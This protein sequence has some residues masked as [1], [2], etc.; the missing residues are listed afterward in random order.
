MPSSAGVG[1]TGV[2]DVTQTPETTAGVADGE[3]TGCGGVEM[4]AAD[5]K[6][7]RTVLL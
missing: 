6:P 3:G 5:H 4:N 1:E 2:S 7:T